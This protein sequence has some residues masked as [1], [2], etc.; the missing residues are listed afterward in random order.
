VEVSTG[1]VM[2]S[3]ARGGGLK[4]VSVAAKQP[5]STS[6]DALALKS[7]RSALT[8]VPLFCFARQDG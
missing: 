2:V 8:P 1:K 4:A 3:V 7:L 6:N 5:G